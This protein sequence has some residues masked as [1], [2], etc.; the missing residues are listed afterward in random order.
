MTSSTVSW[1][2]ALRIALATLGAIG[3]GIGIVATRVVLESQREL[4]RGE[5]LVH[6]GNEHG[7]VR[8]LGY[9]VGWYAPASPYPRRALD[10]LMTLAAAADSRGER[11][12]ALARYRLV[13]ASVLSVR[14]VGIPFEPELRAAD[15]RIA[16]L[17]A[18][19]PPAAI[20]AERPFEERRERFAAELAAAAGADPSPLWTVL[21]LAGFA[22]WV[23]AAFGFAAFAIDSDDRLVGPSARLWGSGILLGLCVWIVGM[24]FA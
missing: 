12:V 17:M 6:A 7:A 3:V 20:D 22:L 8:H 9:A 1:G 16:D 2:A 21:L 18:R 14:S 24:A 11:D 13:R 15:A 4:D 19:M 5:A 10:R 23:G